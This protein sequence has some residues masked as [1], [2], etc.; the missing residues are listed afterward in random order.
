MTWWGVLGLAFSLYGAIV[1]LERLYARI[2]QT[3]GLMPASLTVVLYVINQ[4]GV[5]ERAVSDLS[6]L[7]QNADSQSRDM[8]IMIVDGGSDDQTL[9][10]AKRLERRFPFI[11]VAP[12]GLGKDDILESCRHEVVI[13]VDLTSLTPMVPLGILRTLLLRG[14]PLTIRSIG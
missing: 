11:V 10:I 3:P 5:L 6:E 1:V 14:E 8:E 4:E 2:L 13:W 7:W 9:A 12:L